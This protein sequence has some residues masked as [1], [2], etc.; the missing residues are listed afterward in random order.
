[1]SS[2]HTGSNL[3]GGVLVLLLVGGLAYVATQTNRNTLPAQ[4]GSNSSIVPEGLPATTDTD[5]TPS[6]T[7]ATTPT[8]S[9][10][11]SPLLYMKSV[12]SG[13]QLIKRDNAAKETVLFTDSDSKLK[14]STVLGIVDN[15][16][17]AI[18]SGDDEQSQLAEI[19]LDG[20]GKTNI[21]NA[22]FGGIA[23]AALRTSTRTVAFA[24]FDNS[25]RNFGF[26]LTQEKLDGSG[27][28]T[29]D[30]DTQGISLPIWSQSST[31]LAYVKGQAT[32]D[33]G[34][35]IRIAP[36][37]S[38]PKAVYKL[39]KNTVVTDLV[40]LNDQTL[41]YVVE[42]LGNTTQ[43]KAKTMILHIDSGEQKDLF[44]LPG[45]ER[46]LAVSKDG[47]WLAAIIGDVDQAGAGSG[48]LMLIELS[49]G[50]QTLL[51]SADSVGTW[52]NQ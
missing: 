23:G 13:A 17:V 3:F 51:G 31:T 49:S 19:L 16:A 45:K 32:P 28:T 34:Q 20:T 5:T 9:S 15:K 38:N 50:K 46:S 42:P 4:G 44:D 43:N 21:L 27:R 22:N 48:K 14:L 10:Q 26:T 36:D 30:Q 37:G 2:N 25:E 1:M 35:E 8:V 33:T 24:V 11:V 7:Q 39:E 52:L 12:A 47:G 29:I 18:L 40:W 41:L 6:P